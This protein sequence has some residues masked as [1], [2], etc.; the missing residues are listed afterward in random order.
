MRKKKIKCRYCDLVH[1]FSSKPRPEDTH[2]SDWKRLGLFTLPLLII[3]LV[4]GILVGTFGERGW[5][6]VWLIGTPILLIFV[7]AFLVSI[8]GCNRCVVRLYGRGGG[9]GINF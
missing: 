4:L 8:N 7:P 5:W 3:I 1:K 6:V 2:Y 9:G